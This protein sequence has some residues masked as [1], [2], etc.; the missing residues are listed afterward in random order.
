MTNLCSLISTPAIP[1]SSDSNSHSASI[2]LREESS[3]LSLGV[4]YTSLFPC[5]SSAIVRLVTSV[6]SDSM[7]ISMLNSV[8][9]ENHLNVDKD[10]DS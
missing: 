7:H 2:A 9:V 6:Q 5:R 10:V 8:G 4:K 3:E 1:A